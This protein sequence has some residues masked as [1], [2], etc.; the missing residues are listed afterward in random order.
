MIEAGE[1]KH[2]DFALMA[3]PG[4][5]NVL[6]AKFTASQHLHAEF[7]KSAHASASP[8]EGLNAL[9]AVVLGYQAV[10]LLR[11]Q[12]LP[13]QRINSIITNGG[14]VANIIPTYAKLE[15]SVRS[16]TFSEFLALRERV[17]KCLQGSAKATGTLV[18]LSREPV[19]MDVIINETMAGVYGKYM[20]KLGKNFPP[21]QVQEAK[22]QGSTDMGN[23]SYVVPGF[24]LS[25][26]TAIHPVFDIGV[27][28]DIHTETFGDAAKS[29]TA[30]ENCLANIK[31]LVMTAVEICLDR[32]LLYRV[33]QEFHREKGR[34]G[35]D[36]I[37]AKNE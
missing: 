11:Q 10:S 21:R 31:A 32:D 20:E 24:V 2:V 1:F 16:R 34:R 33:K 30:H 27:E 18:K 7:G 36:F 35:L 4:N 25:D 6:Y 15:H 37:I 12:I 3:H 5:E 28:A 19:Y 29:D 23:V 22:S 26:Y 14:N 9:D 17:E 8:W 13:T